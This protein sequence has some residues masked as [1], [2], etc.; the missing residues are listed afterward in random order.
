MT[1]PV[2]RVDEP[3]DA[4]PVEAAPVDDGT[5][6][7]KPPPPPDGVQASRKGVGLSL[8]IV[9]APVHY[10][11]AKDD[12]DIPGPGPVAAW[13]TALVDADVV[14]L[15][16]LSDD[17]AGTISWFGR[18]YTMRRGLEVVDGAGWDWPSAPA[19]A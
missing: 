11:P 1:A 2:G 12:R 17:G 18:P 6:V 10:Y 16:V 8:P 3:V 5:R 15:A 7:P 13:I 9:G 4:T 14:H 19:K